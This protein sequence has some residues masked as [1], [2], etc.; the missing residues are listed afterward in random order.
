MVTFI[1]GSFIAGVIVGIQLK[2]TLVL[3][4]GKKSKK[5]L[6][7]SIETS[8]ATD[9]E[10]WNVVTDHGKYREVWEI[11]RNNGLLEAI[12]VRDEKAAFDRAVSP[13]E[14]LNPSDDSCSSFSTDSRSLQASRELTIF[15]NTN[16]YDN[17]DKLDELDRAFLLGLVSYF[18][19]MPAKIRQYH[20]D[21]KASR[22][23]AEVIAN[24]YLKTADMIKRVKTKYEVRELIEWIEVLKNKVSPYEHDSNK[25]RWSTG[26]KKDVLAQ[27]RK[28]FS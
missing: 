18:E 25:Y 6:E 8:G 17:L 15:K 19:R 9:A 3:F 11:Y 27:L 2:D 14:S 4:R 5:A 20:R 12:K 7:R 26:L 28:R 10:I 21:H 24:Y 1:I 16:T 22:E 23:E 13:I